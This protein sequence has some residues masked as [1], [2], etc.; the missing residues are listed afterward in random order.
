MHNAQHPKL[1]KLFP[2]F[3]AEF[4]INETDPYIYIYIYI[5]VYIYIY[6]YKPLCVRSEFIGY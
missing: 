1:Q 4:C 5:Y 3:T 6:I 2:S